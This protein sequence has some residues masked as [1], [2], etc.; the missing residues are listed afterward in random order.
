LACPAGSLS[1]KARRKPP[2]C[3]PR[4]RLPICAHSVPPRLRL[5]RRAP[6]KAETP[7]GQPVGLLAVRRSVLNSWRRRPPGLIA[8]N[9]TSAG[10]HRRS[11]WSLPLIVFRHMMGHGKRGSKSGGRSCM[12]AWPMC[13]GRSRTGA[14]AEIIGRKDR[15]TRSIWLVGMASL[16]PPAQLLTPPAERQ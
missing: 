12:L 8:N 2:R 11:R 16:A 13:F 15:S 14:R 9:R 4:K 7:S 5:R 1:W 3:E 10:P 6:M